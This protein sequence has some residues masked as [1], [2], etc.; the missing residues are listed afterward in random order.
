MW[1]CVCVCVR[2]RERERGQHILKSTAEV[3][4]QIVPGEKKNELHELISSL[5]LLFLLKAVFHPSLS[6]AFPGIREIN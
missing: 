4:M 3:L 2:E 1:V 5:P 6:L